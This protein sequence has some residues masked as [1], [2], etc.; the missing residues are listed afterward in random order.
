M[1]S[2]RLVAITFGVVAFVGACGP[3]S[4]DPEATSSNGIGD[5]IE[6]AAA[7]PAEATGE[8]CA[9]ERRTLATAVEAFWAMNGV[10]PTSQDELVGSFLREASQGFEIGAEGAVEA[11]PG[12]PCDGQ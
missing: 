11:I 10:P 3:S 9:I 12:G 6:V 4:A 5:A 8:A 2:H 1:R 7:A